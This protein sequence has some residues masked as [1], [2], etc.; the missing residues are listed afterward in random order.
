[1]ESVAISKNRLLPEEWKVIAKSADDDLGEKSGRRNAALLQARGQVGDHRYR[2]WVPAPHVFA[3][4]QS[5]TQ[6]PSGFVI[7]LFANLRP[8]QAPSSR[9]SK[10]FHNRQKVSAKIVV[11]FLQI[12]LTRRRKRTASVPNG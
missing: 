4:H 9:L 8:N 10:G 2:F 5:P 11:S 1:M 3:A 6:E 7:Q 12:V